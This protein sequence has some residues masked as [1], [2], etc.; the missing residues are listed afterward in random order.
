MHVTCSGC[1][2]GH[3]VP[4]LAMVFPAEPR[5]RGRVARARAILGMAVA[6]LPPGR[7]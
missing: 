3:H 6:G 7:L 4:A 2:C 5:A 1:V